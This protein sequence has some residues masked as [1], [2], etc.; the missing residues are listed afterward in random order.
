MAVPPP[1]VYTRNCAVG[2]E[3]RVITGCHKARPMRPP[4]KRRRKRG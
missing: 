3:R 4:G 1:D 2:R